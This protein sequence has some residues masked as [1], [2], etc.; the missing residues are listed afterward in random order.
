MLLKLPQNGCITCWYRQAAQQPFAYQSSGSVAKK[1]D[2]FS[3]PAGPT[4]KWACSG[5]QLFDKCL[6]LAVL[7]TTSPT[8]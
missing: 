5:G 1:P 7:I 2:N 6:A 8:A 4:R 3:S